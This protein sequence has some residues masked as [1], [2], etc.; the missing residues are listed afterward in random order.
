MSGS[1]YDDV[2]DWVARLGA[3][4]EKLREWMKVCVWMV[5]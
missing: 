5:G 4:V 2:S 1:E 3:S